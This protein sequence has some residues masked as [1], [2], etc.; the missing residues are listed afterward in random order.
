MTTRI[1]ICGITRLE[2][3]LAAI[4]FGA[5]ALGFVFYAKSP[6]FVTPEVA[7]GIIADLPPF[8]TTTALFVDAPAEYVEQVVARTGVDLLQFH[9]S[10]TAAFCRGFSRPYIKALRM[11]PGLD[12]AAVMQAYPEARGIL[13]DAYRAGVPGGTGEAF[14]WDRIPESLRPQ[15][16]LAGGLY[17]ETIRSAIEQ[18]NPFAVDVS[19]GVEA[20]KGIKD[21]NKLKQFIEEVARAD[22]S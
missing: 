21:H 8:V 15:I 14:D 16:I 13:L 7:A 19:G 12:I 22:K 6:R 5:H 9:G 11:K 3:A 20:A 18:V 4:R 2:D 17:P 10:E 1:K